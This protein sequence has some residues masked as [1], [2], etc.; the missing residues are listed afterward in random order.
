MEAL[1]YKAISTTHSAWSGA[2]ATDRRQAEWEWEGSGANVT[3]RRQVR[4]GG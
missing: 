4:M 3:V 1:I 2:N